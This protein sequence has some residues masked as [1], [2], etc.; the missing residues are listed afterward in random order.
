MKLVSAPKEMRQ[1]LVAASWGS[2]FLPTKSVSRTVV[3]PMVSVLYHWGRLVDSQVCLES[4]HLEHFYRNLWHIKCFT[5]AMCYN[6]YNPYL[7]PL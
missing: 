3:I 5:M 7:S 2:S 1:F 6:E 4:P